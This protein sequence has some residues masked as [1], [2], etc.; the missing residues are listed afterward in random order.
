[1]CNYV[2]G[3]MFSSEISGFMGPMVKADTEGVRTGRSS[4]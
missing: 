3:A 4:D 1:M 2:L